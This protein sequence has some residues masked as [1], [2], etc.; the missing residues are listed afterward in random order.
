MFI[1]RKKK[2]FPKGKGSSIMASGFQCECHGFF[3]GI[4]DGKELKSY[5]LF[6]AGTNRDGW[7]TNDD[8]V[9]QLADLIPLM[10]SLHPECDIL[11]AFDNYMTHHKRAPDGLEVH[12]FLPLKDNGKNA[13]LMRNTS[14][15][16]AVGETIE[17]TMMTAQGKQKGIKTILSE[18]GLWDNRMRLECHACM[19]KIP[20]NKRRDY[21]V[22]DFG[23]P[24]YD[25]DH[26]MFTDSCCARGCLRRQPDFAA[27][28]EWL[29][30]VLEK[31]GLLVIYYPKYHCEFNFIELTWGYIKSWLCRN[32]T[33]NYADLKEKVTRLLEPGGIE[34]ERVQ[35][36]ARFC[37]RFMDG[38]RKGLT[39]PILDYTLKKCKSH[40][41][42]PDSLVAQVM[43][44]DGAF[45]KYQENKLPNGK[46]L[47]PRK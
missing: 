33:F 28:K 29:R 6:E 19:N 24:L 25:D 37:F 38:Y 34:T 40:R 30:E 4:I 12:D 31:A 22:D 15:V 9:A 43:G 21:Y 41:C 18:R 36:F 13:P 7:F 46:R 47:A 1:L 32:C 10:K 20:L 26:M 2:I 17:Q 45:A 5:K 42:I 14:F 39:G 27:Q 3:G 35:N 16:N 8:L 11:V 23:E 44:P